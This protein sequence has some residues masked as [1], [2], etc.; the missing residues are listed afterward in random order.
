MAKAKA[1]VEGKI[2]SATLRD[3]RVSPQKA[4]LVVN[5]I[6]GKAVSNALEVLTLCDKKTAPVLRKLLLSAVA[7]A[8]ERSG[9]DPDE[10]FVRRAWVN[11]GRKYKRFMPRAQGRATPIRKRHST[12]TLVL[13]ER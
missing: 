2:S 3:V 10:L 4:R 5:L 7:N 9:V 8:K 12:I 11:Q 13:D 1:A 6:R